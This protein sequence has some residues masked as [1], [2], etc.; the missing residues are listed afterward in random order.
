M[1]IRVI[2]LSAAAMTLALLAASPSPKVAA[3]PDEYM[4]VVSF[5]TGVEGSRSVLP[6]DESAWFNHFNPVIRWASSRRAVEYLV[7]G[8]PDGVSAKAVDS[9]VATLDREIDPRRFR[10]LSESRQVNPCTGEAN[11]ISWEPG[12]GS[13]GVLAMAGVYYNTKTNEIA[14]FR[15]VLDS[16]E[17]WSTKGEADMFDVESVLA[18]EMGHVAG[19]DHVNGRSNALL[20]M[21]PST[22]PGE[23]HKRTL[24]K[25]DLSGLDALYGDDDD[26]RLSRIDGEDGVG[27]YVETVGPNL[28]WD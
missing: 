23:T 9:A 27:E 24:A 5:D 26:M 15:V 2:L 4:E 19:L 11:S 7:V 10:R 22:A 1:N 21:Y 18:H 8:R 16:M 12:D 13:G 14:G 20:T 28:F 6:T 25:G 17:D 3:A